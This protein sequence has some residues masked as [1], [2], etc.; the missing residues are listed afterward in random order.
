[1]SPRARRSPQNAPS[2]P[3]AATEPAASAPPM[4]SAVAARG[5]DDSRLARIAQRAYTIYERRGGQG[6]QELE[7]WLQ[8]EREIDSES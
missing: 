1:M 7:D 5:D 4:A 6:G 8:A 2:T 3:P